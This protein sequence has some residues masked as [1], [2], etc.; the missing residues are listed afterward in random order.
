MKELISNIAKVAKDKI[1]HENLSLYLALVFLIIYPKLINNISLAILFAWLSAL[2]I[3][4]GYEIYQY[5]DDKGSDK[6]DFIWDFTGATLGVI[7]GSLIM[8]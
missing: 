3:G 4:L 8:I 7:L 1:L 6:V 5:I 2:L